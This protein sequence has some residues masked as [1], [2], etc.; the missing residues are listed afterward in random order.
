MTE[1]YIF[2]L[3]KREDRYRNQIWISIKQKCR[4]EIVTNTIWISETLLLRIYAFNQARARKK[5]FK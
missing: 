2:R 1:I 4:I 5:D 3:L